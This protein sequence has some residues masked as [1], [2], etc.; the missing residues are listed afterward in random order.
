MD[1]EIENHGTLYLF[2]LHTDE[3]REWVEQNVE[4]P[5]Y[6]WRGKDVFACEHRYA[7]SLTNGMISAG[8]DVQP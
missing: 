4:V 2:R 7:E 1:I 6:M 3:A 8:L 5:D